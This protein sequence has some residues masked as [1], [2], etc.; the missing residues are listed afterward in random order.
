MAELR[1]RPERE[2]TRSRIPWMLVVLLVVSGLLL[3]RRWW[4]PRVPQGTLVEVVG[5]VARPGLHLIEGEPTVA[6]AVALAGGGMVAPETAVYAGDR[7]VVGSDGVHVEPSGDPLLVAIPV[8]IN[9]ADARTLE[10]LPGVGAATAS[11]IV[12]NR[13]DQGPFSSVD[14]LVRVRGLGPASVDGLRAY[15]SA[16]GGAAVGE[17]LQ[18]PVSVEDKSDGVEVGFSGVEADS[19]VGVSEVVEIDINYASLAELMA[20]RG[21]G[22]V[23][24]ERIV[25][26][27]DSNGAFRS[28]DDLERVAGVGP[29][30]VDRLRDQAVVSP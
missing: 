21:V 3:T 14:A 20:L 28:V 29:R 27:R 25:E 12:D 19:D 6:A 17:A 30:T 23:I 24:A 18:V 7:V 2:P 1:F 16:S 15:V 11:A 5:E 9:F 26:E 4:E 22:P 8:D 10:R 13:R